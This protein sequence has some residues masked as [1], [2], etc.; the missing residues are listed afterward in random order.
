M[1]EQLLSASPAPAVGLVALLKEGLDVRGVDVEK[2]LAGLQVGTYCGCFI[3]RCVA[4]DWSSL[5]FMATYVVAALTSNQICC[6][7][8]SPSRSTE[9][10][11]GLSPILRI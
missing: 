1:L 5:L 4:L 10:V 6:T 11:T 2:R 3:P 9:Y 7:V 8:Q